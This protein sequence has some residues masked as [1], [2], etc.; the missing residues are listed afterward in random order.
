MHILGDSGVLHGDAQGAIGA[1]VQSALCSVRKSSSNVVRGAM[2][3]CLGGSCNFQVPGLSVFDTQQLDENTD[4]QE[5]LLG[6]SLFIRR[7]GK[8]G[9]ETTD[10]EGMPLSGPCTPLAPPSVAPLADHISVAP[11]SPGAEASERS[12]PVNEEDAGEEMCLGMSFI[13]PDTPVDVRWEQVRR[14]FK[15]KH[16]SSQVPSGHQLQR[17][18]EDDKR[19]GES[20]IKSEETSLG[21]LA[22]ASSHPMLPP[23]K[24]IRVPT[25]ASTSTVEVEPQYFA[26]VPRSQL[27]RQCTLSQSKHALGISTEQKEVAHSASA[28]AFLDWAVPVAARHESKDLFDKLAQPRPV[29]AEET[30]EACPPLQPVPAPL[31]SVY[32]SALSSLACQGLHGGPSLLSGFSASKPLLGC[33]SHAVTQ[34]QESSSAHKFIPYAAKMDVLRGSWC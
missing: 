14:R 18:T 27:G 8:S 2:R 7:E 32:T 5:S 23:G 11:F 24:L 16:H 6:A 9:D 22:V 12:D 13:V 29:C 15:S 25:E 4:V 10:E 26:M 3:G 34:G 17:R 30:G 1:L 20:S 31:Q 33:K 28:Q 21:S 19:S